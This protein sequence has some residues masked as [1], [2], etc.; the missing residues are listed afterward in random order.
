MEYVYDVARLK[1]QSGEHGYGERLLRVKVLKTW[2]LL[3]YGQDI[4]YLFHLY[5]NIQLGVLQNEDVC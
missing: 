4:L 2:S 1:S 5:A 3:E